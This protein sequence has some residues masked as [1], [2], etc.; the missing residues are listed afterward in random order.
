M[1]R[2]N[3]GVALKSRK[4]QLPTALWEAIDA[5][6]H[7]PLRDKPRYGAATKYFERL[8]RADLRAKGKI[9]AL[10]EESQDD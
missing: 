8:V 1:A 7:D 2:P 6:H 4:V 5:L 9:E 10:A 3:R